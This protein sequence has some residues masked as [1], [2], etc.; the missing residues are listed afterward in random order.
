MKKECKLILSCYHI[1]LFD[2]AIVRTPRI[3][4]KN[5]YLIHYTAAC[6]LCEKSLEKRTCTSINSLQRVLWLTLL[7]LWNAVKFWL[8]PSENNLDRSKRKAN[9][10]N[11]LNTTWGSIIAIPVRSLRFFTIPSLFNSSPVFVYFL[12]YSCSWIFHPVSCILSIHIKSSVSCFLSSQ[13]PFSSFNY[14]PFAF[15]SF[16]IG[17][18]SML[19]VRFFSASGIENAPILSLAT[20]P[21]ATSRSANQEIFS[22]SERN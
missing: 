20:S 3:G 2:S 1:N 7:N 18:C 10:N 12:F 14:I 16:S 5:N 22:D 8:V 17:S 19:W 9:N 15:L 11:I 4:S 6:I 13:W 21:L